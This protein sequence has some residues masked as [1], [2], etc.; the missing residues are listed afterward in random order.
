M[1]F[2]HNNSSIQVCHGDGLLKNEIGYRLMKKAIRSRVCIFLFR[3]FH[4][5]WGCWLA[6]Q[7]S[8]ISGSYHHHDAKRKSIRD[9]L[10]KYAR[11]QWKAGITTVLLGHYHLTGIVEENGNYLI[12]LG[13]WLQHF[14]VT[15]LDEEGW[16]QGSWNEL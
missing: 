12:F 7:I 6:K 11:T 14:T 9:E 1:D 4:P 15:R 10:I 8:K 5:D 16:W 13:D 2:E 3:N